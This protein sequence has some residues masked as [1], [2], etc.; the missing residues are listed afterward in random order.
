[1][2]CALPCATP[3]AIPELLTVT[4]PVELDAQVA[5]DVQFVLDPS[6]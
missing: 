5:V 6:E 2:I 3:V 1:M 4:T